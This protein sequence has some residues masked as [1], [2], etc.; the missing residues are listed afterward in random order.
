MNQ[1]SRYG[2]FS[3]Y[4]DSKRISSISVYSAPSVLTCTVR[5]EVEPQ[6]PA[7]VQGR[8]H[9]GVVAYRT[10]MRFTD[11]LGHARKNNK[12]WFNVAASTYGVLS[13]DLF[14]SSRGWRTADEVAK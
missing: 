4:S 7:P 14:L 1:D 11:V 12:N 2:Y 3:D 6:I 8:V 13:I 10:T 9:L 5:L